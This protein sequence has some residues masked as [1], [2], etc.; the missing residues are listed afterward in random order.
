MFRDEWE[1]IQ[2][3]P[4]RARGQFISYRGGNIGASFAND[5]VWYIERQWPGVEMPSR[6]AARTAS[7][8]YLPRDAHLV[9]YFQTRAM[10]RYDQY[11]SE[12]LA[13]RFR[14]AAENAEQV[15]PWK[16]AAPGSFIV[17]YRDLGDR[18]SSMVLSTG[19]NPN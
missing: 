6:D 11:S 19:V 17:Y 12:S 10:R 5:I 4:L 7:N 8:E 15:D 18:V 14:L 16:G 1:S 2:G 3:Q 9:G 13:T